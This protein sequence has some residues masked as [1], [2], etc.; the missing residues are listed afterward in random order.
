ML[1]R[2]LCCSFVAVLA[3]P[4]SACSKRDS[5]AAARNQPE[6][7]A[8][9]G[10]DNEEAAFFVELLHRNTYPFLDSGPVEFVSGSDAGPVGTPFELESPPDGTLSIVVPHHPADGRF[11]GLSG[12]GLSLFDDGNALR[13]DFSR[14]LVEFQLVAGDGGDLQVS[15]TGARPGGELTIEPTSGTTFLVHLTP[16]RGFDEGAFTVHRPPG[17]MFALG[18]PASQQLVDFVT[19][20][21]AAYFDFVE[22]STNFSSLVAPGLFVVH[23]EGEPLFTRGQPDRGLGLEHLAED[24]NPFPF[25]DRQQ[26]ELPGLG[27]F[28]DAKIA[29]E[30][31]S[32]TKEST[33]YSF[34]VFAEPG[35]RLSIAAM[36][37]Q[38]NDLFVATSPRG[39]P[40]F[41]NGRPIKGD[42]TSEL[43]LWD[44]G[45]EVNERPG[46]GAHQAARQAESNHGKS[47][48]EPI[49]RV[50]DGFD[51]PP[52]EDLI[53]LSISGG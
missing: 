15:T 42:F 20:G 44:A 31:G 25:I 48:R 34:V 2:L 36:L 35:D 38:T 11:L 52:L 10:E 13:G 4:P 23:A 3:L 28:P 43:T 17:D 49:D 24:G 19:A 32:E 30:E 27:A 33:S 16:P 29:Y 1:R 37:A 50:R 47:E 51:Y 21:D 40:L 22:R 6:P 39:L 41:E 14:K 7:S 9:D 18:Q 45:T 5:A 8:G 46:Y 26:D 53:M 12:G